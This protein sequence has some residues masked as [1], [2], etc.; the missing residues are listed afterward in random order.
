MKD[1]LSHKKDWREVETVLLTEE[2]SVVIQRNLPEKLQDPGSFVIPCNLGD[3]KPKRALCDLETSINLIPVSLIKK[4]DLHQ[5][6]KP[7]RISLQ[8][9]D[10]SAKIPSRVIEDI[11]VRVRPFAFPTNFVVLE[12]EEHHPREIFPGHMKD[13]H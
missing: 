1:I 12:M 13:P 2:Y 6:I 10:S 5:E 8:L 3:A 4:L 11:I 9:A 7:T